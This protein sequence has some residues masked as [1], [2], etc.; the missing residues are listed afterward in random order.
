MP[1]LPA[2]EELAPAPAPLPPLLE[3]L[4]PLALSEVPPRLPVVAPPPPEPPAVS[5]LELPPLEFNAEL[6]PV[7]AL[8]VPLPPIEPVSAAPPT[9]DEPPPVELALPPV[10]VAAPSLLFESPE[11]AKVL[12]E[13]TNTHHTLQRVRI[14]RFVGWIESSLGIELMDGAFFRASPP[15]TVGTGEAVECYAPRVKSPSDQPPAEG[16][17]SN[18]AHEQRSERLGFRRRKSHSAAAFDPRQA[19]AASLPSS[20]DPK[21]ASGRPENDTASGGIARRSQQ[22]GVPVRG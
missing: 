13:P 16:F 4:P 8:S 15:F 6:P 9:E 3:E 11:Q 22:G 14:G 5:P 19:A 20:L 17:G 21:A 1:A 10:A 2:S 18:I 12:S 7:E